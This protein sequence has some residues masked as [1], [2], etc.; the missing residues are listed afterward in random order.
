MTSIT[1]RIMCT[2]AVMAALG[3]YP[4]AAPRVHDVQAYGAKPGDGVDDRAAI[5]RALDAAAM[6][7]E[8]K[9]TGGAAVYFPPGVYDISGPLTL[10]D[11]PLTLRGEGMEVSELRWTVTSGSDGLVA[12][13]TFYGGMP[14]TIRDLTLSTSAAEAGTAIKVDF[15]TADS[16][17]QPT[18]R[19]QNVQVRPHGPAASSV[20]WR[21]GIS[22]DDCWN[23]S[24][25]DVNIHGDTTD[26]D[27]ASGTNRLQYGLLLTGRTNDASI[28]TV[29]IYGAVDQAIRIVSAG[30][31]EVEGPKMSHLV[32]IGADHGVYAAT[33]GEGLPPWLAVTDSH[34]ATRTNGVFLERRHQSSVHGNLFYRDPS[35]PETVNYAAVYAPA[36]GDTRVSN[37]QVVALGKPP[38]AKTAYYGVIAD[39]ND[40]TITGNIFVGVTHGVWIPPGRSG[41]TVVGNRGRDIGRSLVANRGSR[42]HVS[43]N[44]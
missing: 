24:L 34:I 31:H 35:S 18:V 43:G 42:N 40:G 15:P 36:G 9:F 25:S 28:R 11:R 32:I 26:A 4:G 29:T 38:A 16:V 7:G 14:L 12:S 17:S 37:N 5:Q 39:S 6:A 20:G 30:P 27:P 3:L 10:P 22:L 33:S 19:I 23:A 21:V 41:W 44:H 8:E 2:T 13:P 1:R